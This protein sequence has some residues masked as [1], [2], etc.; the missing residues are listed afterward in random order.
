MRQTIVWTKYL[1]REAFR[2]AV[3]KLLK[4]RTQDMKTLLVMIAAV[5]PLT[6]AKRP[7]PNVLFISTTISTRTSP[8]PPTRR[9]TP[10]HLI[11]WQQR[12]LP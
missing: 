2:K 12:V 1:R 8:P 5:L 7:K 10:P 9:F 6:A 11:R 3:R 4:T